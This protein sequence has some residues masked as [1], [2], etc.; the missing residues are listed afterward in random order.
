MELDDSLSFSDI[1]LH[2]STFL[3]LP[4]PP[5]KP[6]KR[7]FIDEITKTALEQRDKSS[8]T[9]SSKSTNF[10]S[11]TSDL[12]YQSENDQ[13]DVQILLLGPSKSGKTTLATTYATGSYL[14]DHIPTLLESFDTQVGVK[15]GRL[16]THTG[17][18]I[19]DTSGNKQIFEKLYERLP[20][21][22]YILFCFDLENYNSDLEE[23][24]LWRDEVI[25]RFGKHS[26]KSKTSIVGCKMETGRFDDCK[27]F[28]KVQKFVKNVFKKDEVFLT[29][30]VT[31]KGV[32]ELF[33]STM[34][35]CI[36]SDE[37]KKSYFCGL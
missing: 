31:E 33:D 24:K 16:N 12:S 36:Y 6:T 29:S 21:P 30:S 13:P 32:K 9:L 26:W 18:R 37:L 20:Q 17:L 34:L 3:S 23:L 4:S 7:K 5:P 2:S 35:K 1:P 22:D 14:N 19:W 27:E 28:K 10:T 8:K 11:F 15:L 25:R